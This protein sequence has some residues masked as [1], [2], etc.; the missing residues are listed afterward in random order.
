MIALAVIPS[1]ILFIIVW[2]NDKTE[3]E[4]VSLLL[5]LFAF[6][7]LTIISAVLIGQTGALL[8]Q[9]ALPETSL[10]YMFIDNFFLTALVE[11][12]GK[13]F[14]LK[15]STWKHP[16]F[17][18]TFDAVVY[19]VC[20]SLG[21][22]TLEN[23]I[24]LID[25]DLGT[26]VLRGLLSVP[27]HVS[28]AIFMGYYY[29]MAKQASVKGDESQKKNYLAKALWIPVIL[30][31]FYDFCL[32]TEYII[33]ILFIVVFEVILSIVAIKKVRKLSVADRS[34]AGDIA[35]GFADTPDHKG[36]KGSE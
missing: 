9:M 16:A 28:Y 2:R 34:I 10:V 32:T 8:L 5:K 30:H 29:G 18:F 35:I 11:E 24:Y 33:L 22:A 26:A 7:A 17:N 36:A 4:P 19:S 14:V 13:Y 6:G 1:I 27:G 25:G 20:A 3:K 12:G 15:K 23:I 31:G 21:F